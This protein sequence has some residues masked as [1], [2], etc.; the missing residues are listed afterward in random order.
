MKLES[1]TIN[2]WFLRSENEVKVIK[3]SSIIDIINCYSLLCVYE[4]NICKF[5]ILC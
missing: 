5:Q 4:L 3:I 2:E 1:T